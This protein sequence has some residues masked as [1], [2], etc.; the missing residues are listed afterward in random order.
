[1]QQVYLALSE[2]P[3]MQTRSKNQARGEVFFVILP[4]VTPFFVSF[5]FKD[6]TIIPF[7]AG[8]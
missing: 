3:A 4:L 8:T 7:D 6:N 1:M 5:C 2:N